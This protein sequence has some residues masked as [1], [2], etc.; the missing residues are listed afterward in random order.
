MIGSMAILI[1]LPVIANT[2]IAVLI[3]SAP[4][5]QVK[6]SQSKS[7]YNTKGKKHN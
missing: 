7:Q 3:C 5:A 4:G 1:F 6:E 2:I